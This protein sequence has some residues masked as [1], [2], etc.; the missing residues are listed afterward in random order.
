S[1]PLEVIPEDALGFAVIKDLSDANARIASLTQKMQ[2]PAPDVL[3]LVKAFT[4]VQGGLDEKGG[5]AIAVQAAEGEGLEAFAP[6]VIVRVT[7]C[8]AFIKSFAPNDPD[9]AIAQVEAFGMSALVAKKG[10][11]AVFG[12]AEQKE[13][14]EK[15]LA[16]TKSVAAV[17]EPLKDWMQK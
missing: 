17:V 13:R 9:A 2:L 5:A 15:F 6:F 10:N 16:A 1:N 8:K 14:L 4:G 12:Q 11:F 7:D 3:S